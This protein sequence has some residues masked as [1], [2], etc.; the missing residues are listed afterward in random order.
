VSFSV[1]VLVVGFGLKEA[2]T[3]VGTLVAESVTLPL[4]P[5]D[6]TT[7]MVLV[8]LE[9]CAAD[10][11]FGLADRVKLAGYQM[12]AFTMLFALTLPSPVAKS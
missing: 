1:L 3:P 8:V 7:V 2:V 11:L 5:P 4:K 10:P 9:P 12:L 6:G